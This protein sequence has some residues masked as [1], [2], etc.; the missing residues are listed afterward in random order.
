MPAGFS[1]ASTTPPEFLSVDTASSTASSTE[2]V[3]DPPAEEPKEEP[4]VLQ[5]AVTLLVEGSITADIQLENLTCKS[6]EKVLPAAQVKAYYIAWYPNDGPELKEAGERVAE[7]EINVSDVG[8]WASR[9]MSWSANDVAPGRYY[10]VVVVD[11]ENVIRAYRM[12]RSEF[13][14]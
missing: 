12:H 11:P 9:S 10:F 1:S 7:Q 13:S 6:C 5:S 3:A 2:P 8:L 4:F 14:M